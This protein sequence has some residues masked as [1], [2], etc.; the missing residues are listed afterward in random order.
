MSNMKI[1]NGYGSE[2]SMNLVMIGRF[3]DAADAAKAKQIID[4]LVEKV[5][6]DVKAGQLDVGEGSDR[7][8][9]GMLDLL[10][11]VNVATIGPNEVEQFA[12]D[13]TVKLKDNQVILTTEESDV[14]AFLKV[15]VDRGARVEVF[16][17]HDYPEAEYGRGK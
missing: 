12:Y 14:S 4:W 6:A 2:H 15:L 5:D 13:V 1:W 3:R 8:T 7:F 10:G 17:A 11:R 16:S 9:A